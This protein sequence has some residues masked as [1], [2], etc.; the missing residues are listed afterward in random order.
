MINLNNHIIRRIRGDLVQFFKIVNGYETINFE[1]D[2]YF[3]RNQPYKLRRHNGRIVRED[4]K[5]SMQRYHFLTNPGVNVWNGL[6][7]Y[8]VNYK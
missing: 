8:I 5:I 3:S 4:V 2:I 6:S 1:N 7:Q